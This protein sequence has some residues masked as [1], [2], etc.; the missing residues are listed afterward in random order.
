MRNGVNQLLL[1]RIQRRVAGTPSGQAMLTDLAEP[2]QQ[3]FDPLAHGFGRIR[4]IEGPQGVAEVAPDVRRQGRRTAHRT[5]LRRSRGMGAMRSFAVR[6]GHSKSPLSPR[7]HD[8]TGS[9]WSDPAKIAQ[10]G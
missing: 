1:C 6:L 5:R 10:Q 4:G 2:N 3:R 8:G 7:R 9:A